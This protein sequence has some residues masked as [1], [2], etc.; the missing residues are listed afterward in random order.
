[1][2][3]RKGKIKEFLKPELCGPWIAVALNDLIDC[4]CQQ[5]ALTTQLM[6]HC[7][8]GPVLQQ[9]RDSPYLVK[10]NNFYSFWSSKDML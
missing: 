2:P 7:E 9:E 6:P 4:L 3:F 8:G 5:L 1:M 10:H